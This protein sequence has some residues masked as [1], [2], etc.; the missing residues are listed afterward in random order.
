MANNIVH[1][2]ESRG[3]AWNTVDAQNVDAKPRPSNPQKW[4][5]AKDDI[6]GS[7]KHQTRGKRVDYRH[8]QDL[9]SDNKIINTKKLTNLLEGNND[10]PTLN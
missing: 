3:N 7:I 4:Q 6:K 8:L 10:Q 5:A 2:G 1:Q 9:F